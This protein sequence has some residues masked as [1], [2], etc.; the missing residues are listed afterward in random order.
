M[1]AHADFWDKNAK[2]YDRFMR[3][4]AV[5]YRQMYEMIRPVVKSKT[6]CHRYGVDRKARRQY[7]KAY[8]SDGCFCGND[9]RSQAG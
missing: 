3:K 4:D 5:A 9:C 2:R 8:R 6:A 7:G 1:E